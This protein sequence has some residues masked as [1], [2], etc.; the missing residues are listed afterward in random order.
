LSR[1][2]MPKIEPIR[3]PEVM[4]YSR[5]RKSAALSPF[6]LICASLGEEAPKITL[7]ATAL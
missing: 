1:N 2:G 5:I 6:C 7:L 3:Q 4:G